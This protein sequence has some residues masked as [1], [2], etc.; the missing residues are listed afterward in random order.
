M[1][2]LHNNHQLLCSPDAF[3]I[4]KILTSEPFNKKHQLYPKKGDFI[5][6][7]HQNYEREYVRFGK[8]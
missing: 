8:T 3:K 1:T 7:E 4:L 6:A 5:K 2:R